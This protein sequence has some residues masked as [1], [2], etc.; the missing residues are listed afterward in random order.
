M[1]ATRHIPLLTSLLAILGSSFLHSAPTV[2]TLEK[3]LH[4]LQTPGALIATSRDGHQPEF[5]AIGH[6]EKFKGKISV[7]AHMRIGSISKLFVGT[8][9]LK[10]TE[11][12]TLHL[13]DPISNYVANVPHGTQITLRMLGTH[14]SG[15]PDAIRNPAFRA[16]IDAKPTRQWTDRE[17]LNFAFAQEN[18]FPPGTQWKYSNT[19]TILLGMALEKSTQLS[20]QTLLEK[21]ICTPLKLKNTAFT[22]SAGLPKPHTAAYR[23]GARDSPASYG[24]TLYNVSTWSA[25]WAGAAGNM[26]STLADLH[27][28]T[29]ALCTGALLLPETKKELHNFQPTPNKNISYGFCIEK[30]HGKL[31]HRGDVPGYSSVLSYDPVSLETLVI[32]TNL[33]NTKTKKH[34]AYQLHQLFSK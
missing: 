14:K 27:R 23:F 3:K 34:P 21:H 29:P 10:L 20:L 2:D 9:V 15:L 32:L 18:H 24:E 31:G 6:A 17:I 5:L 7:D 1:A 28:A 13:D 25:S 30:F 11:N 8:L 26:H 22:T 16:A 33:S 19:N 12:G 4:T